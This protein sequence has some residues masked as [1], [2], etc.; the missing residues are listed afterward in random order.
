MDAGIPLAIDDFSMGR[1]SFQYLE[2]SVFTVVKLDG[3]IAKG[4]LA[5]ERYAD[6]VSSIT[7]LS[8]QLGF[9]VLA[10]YVETAEQ[11]DLLERL[12]CSFFQ[13]YLYAR[14]LPFDEMAERVRTVG[15]GERAE[16]APVSASR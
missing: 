6:I 16:G 5:N 15:A 10:E 13:G 12:G 4:V 8:G 11:R 1:T 7:H 2:T 3:T 9:T 14:A